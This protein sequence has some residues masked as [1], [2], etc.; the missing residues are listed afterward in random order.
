MDS[1]FL[2]AVLLSGAVLAGAPYASAQALA[3]TQNPEH[4]LG[5]FPP[6]PDA[7]PSGSQ[8]A[9]NHKP[10]VKVY[11]NDNLPGAAGGD[12][13]GTDFSAIN[14]CDRNC[15]EQVRQL[16][17]VSPA[18]NPEWKRDLLRALDPVRKDSEWQQFLRDLYD[19]HQGFCQIGEE[20]RE[21]LA[22]VADPQNVTARELN[23]D[24]KYDAR[25]KQAQASLAGLYLR[26]RPLQQRFAY[27]TF[28]YQFSQL[29]VSRIQNAPC[30]A[31]RYTAASPDD[32]DDP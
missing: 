17:H 1:K 16:A 31:Q 22:R 13:D 30:P 5:P 8:L 27:N 7:L 20:K 18:S 28:S 3:P 6:S 9:N 15:F 2:L 26:Q 19:H 4:Y 10:H 23:V 14:D 32:P 25:F 24:D 21:E 29:Q 12:F 11:T